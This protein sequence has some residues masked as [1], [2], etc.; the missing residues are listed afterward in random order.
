MTDDSGHLPFRCLS[1]DLEVGARN[2]RI[3][4]FA[5]IRPDTGQTLIYP[6]ARNDL[7]S[8][9]ARLD[10]LSD[11]AH[12][13]LGHNLIAFDLPHLRAAKPRLKLLRL[14]GVDTLRLNPL[15]FPRNPYHH[16]VKHY[17]D[18]QLKRGRVNDPEL[19]ARLTLE[20]FE[21]QQA[22]LRNAEPDLLTAW[23][24]LTTLDHGEGFDRVFQ[25][26]R[27]TQR[28]TDAEANDA[29]ET[30]L[31]GNSCHSQISAARGTD[32][33]LWLVS[34]LCAGVAVGRP[35]VTR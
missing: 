25:S 34:G 22:A 32:L 6:A 21:N 24:W 30:R 27:R 13:V 11:G 28:P 19:D 20:V 35:G 26:L 7:A 15:A 2:G 23:H 18:G 10:D 9:L 8:A 3:H 12:F 33:T 16:L 5:G 31:V 14:P 29:I 4:A 17:Q 1:L